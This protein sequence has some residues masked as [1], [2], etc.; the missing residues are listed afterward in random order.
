MSETTQDDAVAQEAAQR[1]V[2]TSAGVWD[3]TDARRRF[4]VSGRDRVK[5]LQNMTSQDV[6]G[7]APGEAALTCALTVKAKLVGIARIL[8]RA[9]DFLLDVEAGCAEAL[10]AHLRKY[11][12]VNQ[13]VFED[14]T[15]AT[16]AIAVEGPEAEA[17]IG[18]ARDA[19]GPDAAV[20]PITISGE[21]G[22]RA[23]I[24]RARREAALR[25]LSA[26][27]PPVPTQAVEALR[28]ESG[29]PAWGKEL[30][31]ATFPPEANLDRTAIS[32]TKGCFLG[33]EPIARL[34]FMG[35]LNRRLMG[36]VLA[37]GATLPPPGVK[38]RAPDGKEVGR[39]TS[40]ALSPSLGRLVA[41]GYVR[42]EV[43]APGTRLTAALPEGAW[44]CEVEVRDLP[45]VAPTAPPPA[46]PAAPAGPPPKAAG[47]VTPGGAAEG[48][49]LLPGAG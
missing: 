22:G 17:R 20:A 32:Y 26:G 5:F 39:L 34:H 21:R 35:H 25:A 31:E 36:L 24:D 48:G 46:K 30:D 9:D 27:A 19:L 43:N 40:A 42:K 29:V 23:Y 16:A 14:R 6:K 37:E 13:V 47:G 44:T 38:L 28:V 41:L 10:I 7:L 2:R 4:R 49:L 11:V 45:L 12:V 8:A 15:D 3:E 18:D 33:Q 1:M